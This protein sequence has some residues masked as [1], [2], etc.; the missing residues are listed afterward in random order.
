MNA[1]AETAFIYFDWADASISYKQPLIAAPHS[2]QCLSWTQC[3]CVCDITEKNRGENHVFCAQPPRWQEDRKSTETSPTSLNP[4]KHSDTFAA[5]GKDRPVALSGFVEMWR[6]VGWFLIL[7]QTFV[8]SRSV[9]VGWSVGVSDPLNLH[10][11]HGG[12]RRGAG[13]FSSY[14]DRFECWC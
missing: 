1:D 10:T 12:G 11:S 5:P 9:Q 3:V 4:L 14:D 2:E 6:G 13:V 8:S 7:A